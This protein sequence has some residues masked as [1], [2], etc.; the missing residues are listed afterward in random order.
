MCVCRFFAVV[1]GWVILVSGVR[2][3]VFVKLR[4]RLDLCVCSALCALSRAPVLKQSMVRFAFA[5]SAAMLLVLATGAS[6]AHTL[7]SPPRPSNTRNKHADV[8]FNVGGMMIKASSAKPADPMRL[9]GIHK[10]IY[11]CICFLALSLFSR[12]RW[13]G[14]PRDLLYLRARP[15]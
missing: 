4:H 5:C 8:V 2:S 7:S 9:R 13:D 3:S 11:L 10:S 14:G 12:G 6:A 15:K 1:R